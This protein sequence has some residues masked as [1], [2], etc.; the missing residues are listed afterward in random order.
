[1]DL[2]PLRHEEVRD[3]LEGNGYDELDFAS[4]SLARPR[5]GMMPARIRDLSIQG[6]RIEG[7]MSL[8][9]GEAAV[10]DLHLPDERVVIKALGEVVWSRPSQDSQPP[11]AFGL[12]FAALK[13]DALARLKHYLTLMPQGA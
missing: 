4:L 13:D 6:A 10:L 8:G 12:R 5:S 9:L 7:P 1:V 11:H 2:K 3:I